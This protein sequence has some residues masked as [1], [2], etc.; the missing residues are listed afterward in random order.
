[1]NLIVRPNLWMG[2]WMGLG[3]GPCSFAFSALAA[4]TPASSGA[5][6]TLIVCPSADSGCDFSGKL[7]IQAAV[8]A[9]GDGDI[10]KLRAGVYQ[11]E[12][13]R[14]ILYK[15]YLIR[16]FVTVDGKRIELVGEP[17]AVLD[18]A[19][20]P[21]VSALVVRDA[22]VTIRNLTIRNFRAGA[23]EDD[24]YEGHGIFVIDSRAELRNVNI[25]RYEK[26]ALTGRGSTLLNASELR[27][28]D[29]HVAIWLEETAHLRLCNSL[30]RNNDSA[31]VAVYV[32][33]SA[34]IYNS[35]FDGNRDDGLYATGAASI[36]ATNTLLLGNR[37]FAVRVE[38]HA[39]ATVMHSV[40]FGNEALISTPK[41]T[42]NITLGVLFDDP[43]VD[44][45]YH[46]V[47]PLE[48][49]PDVRAADGGRS[50]IGLGATAGC[51]GLPGT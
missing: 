30:V 49:D 5:A 36:V 41:D 10:V 1:M 12:R 21:P 13:F 23:K 51:T 38:D 22:D 46:W 11:P 40:L 3:I 31:G 33:A 28:V 39:R 50:R 6:K 29:G 19:S 37:P 26:M 27:I 32:N 8:D 34:T 15:Q 4:P 16:G 17:G 35:V 45:S 2:L 44:A 18:G 42:Q 9:A 14:D 7:G 20:G 47:K 25:E 48:G 24:L 43:K